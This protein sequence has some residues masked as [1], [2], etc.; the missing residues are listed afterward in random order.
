LGYL[1]YCIGVVLF[2]ATIGVV[3]GAAS[4]VQEAVGGLTLVAGAVFF[5][6]GAISN[7]IAE[8]NDLLQ[9]IRNENREARE[10]ETNDKEAA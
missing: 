10:L 5:C 8:S 9:Q 4:A 1:F 2:I 7:G 6:S 3:S